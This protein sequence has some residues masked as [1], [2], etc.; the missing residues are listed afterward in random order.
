MTVDQLE[1]VRQQPEP[2]RKEWSS[3]SSYLPAADLGSW[4]GIIRRRKWV[5]ILC[6]LLVTSAAAGII[7]SLTSLYQATSSILIDERQPQLADLQSIVSGLPV[8]RST[9]ESE[10]AVML[11]RDFADRVIQKLKLFELPEFNPVLRNPNQFDEIKSK[12]GTL[13][14]KQTEGIIAADPTPV[15][16]AEQQ[17]D[18]ERVLVINT[19]LKKIEVRARGDTLVIDITATTEAPEIAADVANTIAELY[20]VDQLEAKYQATKRAT[21]WLTDRI[22]QLR[23]DLEAAESAVENYRSSAGLLTGAGEVTLKQ[24]QMSDIS[25]QLIT[26][27]INRTQVEARLRQAEALLRSPAGAS[28]ASEVLQSPVIQNLLAQETE[29]LRKIADL[30]SKVGENF[31]AMIS[32]RAEARDLRSK[33]TAEISQVVASLRNEVAVARAQ[34][35]TFENTLQELEA[36]MGTLNSRDAELRVLEREA[37]SSQLLYETFL[38]RFK[39]LQDQEKIQQSDARVISRADVPFGPS[40]PNRPLLLALAALGSVFLGFLIIGALEMFDRGL[41]SMEEVYY[42]LDLPCF[43]LIPTISTFR[44]AGKSVE[45]YAIK[46]P[47]CAYAEAIRSVTTGLLLTDSKSKSHVIAVTSARPNEGKTAIAI[48]MAALNALG[49]RKSIILDLDLRKPEIRDRLRSKA[50]IGFVD[51][52]AGQ[53]PLAEVIQKEEASGLDFIVAGHRKANFAEVIRSSKLEGLL[54]EL[55]QQYDLIVLDTP[56]VLAVADTRLLARLA[57]KTLLVVRWAETGR[58]VVRLALRQMSDAGADIAGIAISMVDVRRNSK[59][60]F[61]DSGSFTGAFKQYYGG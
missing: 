43:G 46:K 16:S 28:S 14:E 11:S 30:S 48:S 1:K 42:Y 53:I 12:V 56:P 10:T 40:L 39:E 17:F 58:D 57:D 21:D 38:S 26:A 44:L 13:V 59:Y 61:G 31:P 27:R 47:A 54:G 23:S 33:I 29:V 8:G 20:L 18:R 55:R 60:G 32:A 6:S 50:D 34:E 7:F 3:Q 52:L 15:S 36:K 5:L 2:R 41:H 4:L 49:G 45:S 37:Q 35:A 51:Y 22:S 9:V 24:Q 25:T 19:F